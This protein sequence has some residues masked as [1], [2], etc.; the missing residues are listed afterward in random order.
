MC[1]SRAQRGERA[2]V[3]VEERN[4]A[5]QEMGKEDVTM[6]QPQEACEIED[7]TRTEVNCQPL[8]MSLC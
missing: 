2:S 7:S 4:T 1:G 8:T 5:L 6:S 3:R